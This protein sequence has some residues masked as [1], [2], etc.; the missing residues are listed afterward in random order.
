MFFQWEKVWRNFSPNFSTNLDVCAVS[1][2]KLS[3]EPTLTKFGFITPE[4][5]LYAPS[6]FIVQ[7][8]DV[9]TFFFSLWNY[10]ENLGIDSHID[11]VAQRKDEHKRK[12]YKEYVIVASF[13]FYGIFSNIIP[14]VF[15]NVDTLH[16]T[17]ELKPH[18]SLF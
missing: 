3:S 2:P 12:K 1:F 18:S 7:I 11:V 5:T 6:T 10:I 4:Y 14:I 17:V 16:V 9:L 8:F 13:W 15:Q